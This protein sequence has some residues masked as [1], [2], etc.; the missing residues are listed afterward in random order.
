MGAW[1]TTL[2][3]AHTG[4]ALALIWAEMCW[5]PEQGMLQAPSHPTAGS[6]QTSTGIAEERER[7]PLK[8]AL[9]LRCD[10]RNEM[11]CKQLDL[12]SG[13]ALCPWHGLGMHRDRHLCSAP[14]G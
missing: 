6:A 12:E 9:S 3:V 4:G 11:Q 8:N 1:L 10:L 13:P 2:P 7:F 5:S 14:F